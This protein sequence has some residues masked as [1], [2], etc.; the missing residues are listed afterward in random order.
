MF[1]FGKFHG[2]CRNDRIQLTREQISRVS[3]FLRDRSASASSL[4]YAP[5]D[6]SVERRSPPLAGN[7]F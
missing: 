3:F 4:Q 2:M 7:C 6:F 1:R 5:S